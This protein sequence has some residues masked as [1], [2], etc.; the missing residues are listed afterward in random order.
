LRYEVADPA[1]PAVVL[2]KAHVPFFP[3]SFSEGKLKEEERVRGGGSFHSKLASEEAP[4]AEAEEREAERV[5]FVLAMLI[6]FGMRKG[7]GLPSLVLE[8]GLKVVEDGTGVNDRVTRPVPT[9]L[10]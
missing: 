5:F 9:S 8:E 4:E 2:I 1:G 3:L 10:P 7:R 6:S